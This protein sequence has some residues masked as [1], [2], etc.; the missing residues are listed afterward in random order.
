MEG[1]S[2]E[3]MAAL[4]N[5]LTELAD[6]GDRAALR[7]LSDE[8][9]S[10]VALLDR[11]G[12]L[13]RT[14]ADPALPKRAKVGLL[15]QLLGSQLGTDTMTLVRQVAESRWSS[16]GDL[17]DA[18]EV[19]AALAAFIAADAQG[20]LDEVEDALFRFGRIVDREP[21]LRSALSDPVLPV[22]RKVELV[23]ALLEGKVDP[24]TERLVEI[25]VTAPRGRP[26]DRS[27]DEFARLAADSR[28]QLVARVVVAVPLED[29]Q[30]Q[31][32]AAA[33]GEVF[34]RRMQLQVE[35]DRAL[36]GGLVVR[37]GDEVIDAS[38][39][40]RLADVRRRLSR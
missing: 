1:A 16:P 14:L 23:H 15:D 8:L 19:L 11:E 36:V 37:V 25:A 27:I 17:V 7:G 9:F 3:S 33:L 31:R 29:E 34:G 10:L 22:E 40:S 20:I 28:N 13:R 12:S 26:I 38:I 39:A 32:L 18:V 30:E 21:G 24:I 6:G 35:V 5:R 4:R 2:R